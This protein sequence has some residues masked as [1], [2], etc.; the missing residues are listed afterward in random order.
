MSLF[1]PDSERDNI[2]CDVRPCSPWKASAR[3]RGTPAHAGARLCTVVDEHTTRLRVIGPDGGQLTTR[4]VVPACFRRL[5]R[6]GGPPLPR[7]EASS[8]RPLPPA[9]VYQDDSLRGRSVD[10][11]FKLCRGDFPRIAL[12]AF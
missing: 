8:R 12:S 1:V 3:C 7:P 4:V 5:E 10:L 9:L 2:M 6:P 11:L